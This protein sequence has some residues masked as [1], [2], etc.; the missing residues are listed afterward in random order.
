MTTIRSRRQS[1]SADL[2]QFT[3]QQNT[4]SSIGALH[5]TEQGVCHLGRG[6]GS[7]VRWNQ[8]LQEGHGRA[9]ESLAGTLGLAE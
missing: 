6:D 3:G 1:D 4:G 5:G 8:R 7:I 9:P 2:P